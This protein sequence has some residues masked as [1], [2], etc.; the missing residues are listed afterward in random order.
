MLDYEP[1]LTQTATRSDPASARRRQAQI[2]RI[3]LHAA[4]A[5]RL[6]RAAHSASAGRGRVRPN[7]SSSCGSSIPRWAAPRFSFRHAGI[8]RSAYERALIREGSSPRTRSRRSG[9]GHVQA[10]C[11][12]AMPLWCRPESDGGAAR[13]AVPLARDAVGRQAADISRSPPRLRQQ[14][15]RRVAHRYRTA[16]AGPRSRRARAH[17]DMPLF[18][19]ADLEPSLARAVAER[20]WLAETADDTADV[21]REKERRLER[22]RI[23]ER[24]KSVADLWCACWMWPDTQAAPDQAVFASLADQL[25]TGRS[26]LPDK[27]LD[28]LLQRR[29]RRCR[30][31]PLP[32]LD[33]RVS[34]SLFR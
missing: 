1:A 30:R 24:W 23:A 2:D 13:A 22:L 3:V 16:A 17:A 31:A 28:R 25:T 15:A 4:N 11:R 32:S 10:A 21:V 9:S 29:R 18:S 34:R 12:A 8:S 19:D 26:G 20:R 27:T 33:A 7:A 6:R 5:Y 14:P